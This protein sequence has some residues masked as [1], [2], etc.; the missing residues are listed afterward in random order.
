[1]V[2]WGVRGLYEAPAIEHKGCPPTMG[3]E[4][5]RAIKHPAVIGLD[6]L[7]APVSVVEEVLGCQHVGIFLS[8]S[9]GELDS[10]TNRNGIFSSSIH[11][12]FQ[13]KRPERDNRNSIAVRNNRTKPKSG[14]WAGSW[15]PNYLLELRSWHPLRYYH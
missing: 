6:S 1:M 14:Y 2:P 4:S 9:E 10:V 13:S 15:D 3:G 7:R 12:S 8:L 5:P 11:A